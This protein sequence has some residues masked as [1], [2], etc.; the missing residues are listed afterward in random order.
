MSRVLKTSR[1]T[2]KQVYRAEVETACRVGIS[3]GFTFEGRLI[4]LVIAMPYLDYMALPKSPY[5]DLPEIAPK[6][7]VHKKIHS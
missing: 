5:E 1:E 6:K 4:S 3:Y 7:A 2:F